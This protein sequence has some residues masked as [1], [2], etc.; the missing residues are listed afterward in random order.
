VERALRAFLLSGTRLDVLDVGCGTGYWLTRL[1]SADRRVVGLDAS[2]AMLHQIPRRERFE[3][4][5][6]R[7]EALPLEAGKFDRVFC[8]NSLHHFADKRAFIGEARRV[9]RGGGGFMTVG[10]D[11]HTGLD[12]WWVYDYFEHS[13]ERDKQRYPST[14]DICDVLAEYGFVNCRTELVQ[15]FSRLDSA[16]RSMERGDLARTVTSQLALLTDEEYDRGL[17]RIREG[18]LDA[19]ESGQELVLTVDLRLFATTGWLG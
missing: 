8:L 3:L 12:K 15:C 7:A 14:N 19:E 2:A 5:H 6:A 10:L 9:L 11:P 17:E 13:L 16:R 4:V 1:A 18:I